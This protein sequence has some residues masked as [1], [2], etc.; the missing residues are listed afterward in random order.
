MLKTSA[1]KYEGNILVSLSLWRLRVALNYRTEIIFH[2]WG[3]TNCSDRLRKQLLL[4]IK[5]IF[6]VQKRHDNSWE[7]KKN[8]SDEK[9]IDIFIYSD[10]KMCYRNSKRIRVF[11]WLMFSGFLAWLRFHKFNFSSVSQSCIL[12][13][14]EDICQC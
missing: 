13:H 5:C 14:C 7:W 4:T 3:K 11:S 12:S 1:H 9:K 6:K 10:W 8:H 2:V